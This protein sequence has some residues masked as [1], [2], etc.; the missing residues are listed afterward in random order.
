MARAGG[1]SDSGCRMA[2][3]FFDYRM[4]DQSV[5]DYH[6]N[7]FRSSQDAFE[8]AKVIAEDLAHRLA[9]DWHGW[10]VEVRDALGMKVFC[11]P[12]DARGAS[13]V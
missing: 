13:R 4:N 2:R 8:F 11:L 7:E 12:V 3:F 9:E 1:G 5:L 10:T 6:G